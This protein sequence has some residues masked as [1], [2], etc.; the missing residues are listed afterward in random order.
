MSGDLITRTLTHPVSLRSTGG[1]RTISGYAVRFGELS[2][3]LGGF[4][5]RIAHSAWDPAAASGDVIATFNHDKN[6]LLGRVSAGTLRI[7]R[8]AEGLWFELDLPDTAAGRDVG[9]LVRTRNVAGCSFTFAVRPG[10]VRVADDRDPE[11]G[12]PIREITAMEVYEVGPVV[13]PAYPTTTVGARSLD[14]EIGSMPDTIRTSGGFMPTNRRA[15]SDGTSWA[16]TEVSALWR[17]L[18]GPRSAFLPALPS[19]NKLRM[20]QASLLMPAIRTATG[21]LVATGT[22]ISQPG[23]DIT[24]RTCWATKFGAAE[25]ASHEVLT[26]AAPDLRAGLNQSLA[27][28]VARAIDDGLFNGAAPTDEN[29][30]RRVVG[31]LS[32]AVVTNVEETPSVADISAAIGRIEDIDGTARVL[33]VDPVTAKALRDEIGAADWPKGVYGT[34]PV[35]SSLLPAGTAVVA[36]SES[37]FVGLHDDVRVDVSRFGAS[38]GT[39]QVAFRALARV[40]GVWVIDAGAVQVVSTTLPDAEPDLMAL[41]DTVTSDVNSVEAMRARAIEDAADR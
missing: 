36:D 29:D 39:D 6:L 37:V 3:N 9:E 27:L 2:H 30:P 19:A 14:K 15:I 26:D 23:T 40:A 1:V 8:D 10:G 41:A 16:A 20:T 5:E 13:T 4:R 7:S 34:T 21:G 38:F 31:L 12:L 18:I 32:Q 28:A 17:D 22:A 25:I 24:S 33:W 35:V 11:S